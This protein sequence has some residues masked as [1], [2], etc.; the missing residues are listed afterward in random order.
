[1]RCFERL[2]QR[3][4]LGLQ[5]SVALGNQTLTI[6]GNANATF[7]GAIGS[8]GGGFT[9]GDGTHAASETLTGGDD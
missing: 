4:K 3:I 7:A 5:T 1:M 2:A 9:I 8:T 6:T